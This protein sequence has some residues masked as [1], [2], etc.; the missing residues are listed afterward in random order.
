MTHTIRCLRSLM[1]RH[2]IRAAD[3]A[4]KIEI[5]TASLSRIL[6]GRSA[7]SHETLRFMIRLVAADESESRE[8]IRCHLLDEIA[9]LDSGDLAALTVGDG[10]TGRGDEDVLSAMAD[11]VRSFDEIGMLAKRIGELS[12][13]TR[14]RLS[15]GEKPEIA[16]TTIPVAKRGSRRKA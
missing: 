3:L 9:R 1:D 10:A 4:R 2:G 13:A 14:G 8:I 12:Q 6:S 11:A 7:P 16:T 5:S 15:P